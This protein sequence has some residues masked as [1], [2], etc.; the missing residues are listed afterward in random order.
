MEIFHLKSYK[1]RFQNK[2]CNSE[3]C[4]RCLLISNQ[5]L[6]SIDV[7][8]LLIRTQLEYRDTIGSESKLDCLEE[9][10]L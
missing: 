2:Y 7:T 1:N 6:S 10:N 5:A 9:K 3:F 8:I 4:I